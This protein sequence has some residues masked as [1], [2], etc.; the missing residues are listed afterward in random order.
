MI[1]LGWSEA[2]GRTAAPSPGRYTEIKQARIRMRP[3]PAQAEGRKPDD[4]PRVS[5]GSS[6]AHTAEASS[7]ESSVGREIVGL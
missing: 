3:L 5:D 7:S 4:V 2:G 6:D 1:A